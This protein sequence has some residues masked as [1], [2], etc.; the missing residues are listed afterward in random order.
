[1]TRTISRRL[2]IIRRWIFFV[3]V[4]AAVLGPVFLQ[5][6]HVRQL[7]HVASEINPGDTRAEVLEILGKPG[8][9]YYSGYPARGGYPTVSGSCYGGVLNSIWSHMDSLVARLPRWYAGYDWYTEHVA[10]DLTTWPVTI[11]FDRNGEVISVNR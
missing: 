11:E 6:A 10:Q 5:V 3:L 8:V 9:T 7:Q 1:M 4:V 2:I